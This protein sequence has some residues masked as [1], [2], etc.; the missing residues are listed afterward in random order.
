MITSQKLMTL[1]LTSEVLRKC[2]GSSRVR[3]KYGLALV[4][5]TA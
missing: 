4:G 2:F 1:E 3:P 5:G